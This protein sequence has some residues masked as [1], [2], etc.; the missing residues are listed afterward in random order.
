M[1]AMSAAAQASQIQLRLATEA[2]I[3]KIVA[4]VNRA[5]QVEAFFLM[6]ERTDVA[7]VTEM[8][9]KGEFL[10]AEIEGQML[11]CVYLEKRGDRAYFGM[12][13][14]EPNRKGFGLG[15]FLIDAV[16]ERARLQGCVAMDI[17]VV[18]LRTEL[19]PFYQKFGYEISGE[20]PA[21][22]MRSRIPCHLIQMSKSLTHV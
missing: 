17:T 9:Q 11:G 16:E 4:L 21:T 12:L 22:H 20:L 19:P 2:D 3:P 13:S 8:F 18:N 7:N 10:L 5:F 15:R 1:I 6:N 14:V